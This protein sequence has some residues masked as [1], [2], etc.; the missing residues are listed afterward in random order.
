MKKFLMILFASFFV[1][2]AAPAPRSF[3]GSDAGIYQDNVLDQFGDW[4]ATM[5]KNGTEKESVLAQRK[6]DRQVK[7]AAKQAE[8][9]SKEAEKAGSDMK[10]KM[11]F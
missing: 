4:V 1:F 5:G 7:Y 10:K 8:Q 2:S 9:V 6:A 3:A 11:G